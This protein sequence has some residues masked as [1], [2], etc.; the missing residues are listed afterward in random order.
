MKTQHPIPQ[1]VLLLESRSAFIS[2]HGGYGHRQKKLDYAAVCFDYNEVRIDA[3]NEETAL[4]SSPGATTL[5]QRDLC[6]EQQWL[7]QLDTTKIFK[8]STRHIY[9]PVP[10]PKSFYA[11]VEDEDWYHF[12]KHSV[13]EL[14]ASG[15][16]VKISD[17]F[18]FN[19]QEIDHIHGEIGQNEVG[20]FDIALVGVVDRQRIR[21]EPLLTELFAR[22]SRWLHNPAIIPDEERVR[23]ITENNAPLIVRAR[24]LKPMV[25]SFLDLFEPSQQPVLRIPVWD[26]GRL[27]TL[28]AHDKW[29]FSGRA[30]LRDVVRH[31]HEGT[32]FETI[33]LPQGLQTTLRPYQ[34]HGLNWMQFLRQHHLAGVL[35]D[36]MGLGKTVQALAHILTEKEAQR[37]VQPA[38][39]V[40]PT[41]LIYSW[42]QEAAR[43]TPGLRVLALTGVQ[44]KQHFTRL[45]EY[46][47]ILTTYALIWRDLEILREQMWHLLILDE[48]HYVKNNRTR[49]AQAIRSLAA[50]HRLCLTGT[51]LENHLGELWAQFDFLLPGFLGNEKD[52]TLHWR[53]PIEREGN[54][55]KRALLARRIQPFILRRRKSDVANELPSKTVIVRKV[56]LEGSQR[57]LYETVKRTLRNQLNQKN[58]RYASQRHPGQV[59]DALLKL[60]QICCDPRLVR[61]E[62]A[63]KSKHS[64]K[65]ALLCE[66][67]GSLLHEGHRILIFSQ[68]SGML[69]LIAS[70]LSKAKVNWVILTGNT[71]DRTTPVQR[72]QKGEVPV[73]L[74]SLKAGGIGLNLTAAD[75]VIHYD[76]WWNP[77]AEAQATDRAYRIGQDKPVFV[78]KLIAAGTIEENIVSLQERK[79]QLSGSLF[80]EESA[81]TFS[82]AEMA[83]LLESMY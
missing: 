15:W 6:C 79:A 22:D 36:D 29:H 1:P 10:L 40:L 66:M 57:N 44:R 83:A 31:L 80:A 54:S 20:W 30:A 12:V 55:V 81:S 5:I 76:P 21:L 18:S 78:Y 32:V 53:Q 68:F 65:L 73:F 75:T 52:F 37:L 56:E 50:K 23:L 61:L 33:A 27:E 9:T 24:R 34:L 70:E 59:L 4:P 49:A 51:P 2:G 43:F 45:T 74:I 41:T 8:I 14:Q 72:F 67:V 28:D 77:A 11:P 71:T 46:D 48:A 64:A 35:A 7:S 26:V 19:V 42:Q 3:G 38:L 17:D 60:R 25:S 58:K 47:V 82:E 13:P 63:R 62:E 69:A 16:L 39:I